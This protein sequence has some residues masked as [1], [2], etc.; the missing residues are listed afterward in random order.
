MVWFF[1]LN[2]KYNIHLLTAEVNSSLDF[3]LYKNFQTIFCEKE[4]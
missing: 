2:L 4:C 3:A 1:S